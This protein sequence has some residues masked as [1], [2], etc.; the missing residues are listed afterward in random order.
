MAQPRSQG[1]RA[2]DTIGEY[3]TH[4]RRWG[5]C[6]DAVRDQEG[7]NWKY[8]MTHPVLPEIGRTELETF[9]GWLQRQAD[10]GRR[11]WSA[12]TVNK[13]LGTIR[14]VGEAAVRH[15]LLPAFPKLD[16][17]PETK[18]GRKLHLSYDEADALKQACRVAAWPTGLPAPAALYWETIV[19]GFCVYGF[20]TQEQAKYESAM[21]ELRWPDIRDQAETP[22]PDGKAS[23]RLGWLVYTPQKQE[24]LKSK[25]LVLPLVE[26]YH[27]HLTA[28]RAFGGDPQGSVFPFPLSNEKFYATWR[29]IVAA[30]GVRPKPGLDG[31]QPEYQIKHLRKTATKWL[32]DHGA[33]IGCPGVAPYIVG[34]A[35]ERSASKVSDTH[36]DHPEQRVLAALTTLP[37]PPSFHEPLYVG[38]RQLVLF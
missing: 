11:G 20:R 7:Q 18:A 16:P 36:Y 38:R 29:A 3:E 26:A 14:A 6:W 1:G 8:R 12:R 5:E 33:Q 10:G 32:N 27:R 2:A 19:V 25:P 4:L 35:A 34:H 30:A 23:W 28:I 13:H 22:D 31:L 9:R 15:E 21:R 17:L 24:R 37:L